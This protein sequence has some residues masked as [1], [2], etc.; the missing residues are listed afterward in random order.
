M[1]SALRKRMHLSPA[2]VIA[3][4]ALVFAMTG[5]AYAANRYLITSTKQI[6]P[7]VLKALQGKAGPA[8]ANG[9]QGPAGPAGA[10]GLAGAAGAGTPGATGSQGPAGPAGA[11][12]TNGK[13]GK[14][15]T[16]GF[17]ETLPSKKTETGTWAFNATAKGEVYV[18]ISF[19]IPLGAPIAEHNVHYVPA[20]FTL[21]SCE[22][23]TGTELAECVG[24]RKV[25][26]EKARSQSLKK[27]ARAPSKRQRPRPGNLCVYET[28]FLT[29]NSRRSTIPRQAARGP[30]RLEPSSGSKSKTKNHYAKVLARG[31]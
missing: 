1:F 26:E 19:S 28:L 10:T 3:S 6:S 2:T 20:N 4:L 21:R 31:R 12:G 24:A 27:R 29:P 23:L 14:D 30:R 16:T 17:T 25:E 18:P 22:G 13:D 11:N 7:K 8:G 15:G 9:A 5:G